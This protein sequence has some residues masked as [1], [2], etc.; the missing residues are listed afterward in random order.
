MSILEIVLSVMTVSLT[1]GYITLAL[2][3]FKSIETI[4]ILI[5]D[6]IVLRD[7]LEDNA[8]VNTEQEAFDTHT[9]NFIKFLSDSREW[10]FDYIENSM[11]E[12]KGIIHLIESRPGD[13]GI[14]DG[15]K[16]RLETLIDNERKKDE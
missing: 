15:I 12:V 3:F 11:R 16:S 5:Q 8:V 9:E 14:I 7:F 1:I 6:Y 10:A 13:P 2:K 4:N